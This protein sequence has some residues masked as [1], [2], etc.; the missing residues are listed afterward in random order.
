[1]KCWTFVLLVILVC[2]F[3]GCAKYYYQEGKSF[4]QCQKDRAD[5]L[6]EL[7]KRLAVQT[8]RPGGY[9]YKFI[10]DCMKHRGYGLVTEDKL[11][12][13]V[14]RQDPAQTLRG[15]LY[16]ERRGMAGAVGEE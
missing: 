15:I 4:V 12:L 5:C 9:E 16:G 13:G 11:P 14:K 1:M 6:A 2:S 10:E 7:N 8:R 3:S